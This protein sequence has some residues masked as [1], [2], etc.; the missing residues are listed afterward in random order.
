MD[1][2]DR[3]DPQR[4]QDL[5]MVAVKEKSNLVRKRIGDE[6]AHVTCRYD[7]ISKKFLFA[8]VFALV[9]RYIGVEISDGQY[10]FEAT[11]SSTSKLAFEWH[12]EVA[13]GVRREIV[14]SFRSNIVKR[15]VP[16]PDC[17]RRTQVFTAELESLASRSALQ[18]QVPLR[19]KLGCRDVEISC[20]YI[21]VVMPGGY[22]QNAPIHRQ[23][24]IG[25]RWVLRTP[26]WEWKEETAMRMKDVESRDVPLPKCTITR[27]RFADI[28]KEAAKKVSD[29]FSLT[30]SC[31]C[32]P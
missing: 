23:S 14:S 20:N 27:Q 7:L 10:D 8:A 31:K 6:K 3:L 29:K 24:R 16:A 9:L 21:G 15:G 26:D 1:T 18:A 13:D 28:A 11:G 5:A 22:D 19:E 2:A 25:F 4:L 30:V 12:I 32:R 17:A